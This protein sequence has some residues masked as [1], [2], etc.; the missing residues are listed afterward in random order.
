MFDVSDDAKGEFRRVEVLTGP[1]RR[2]RWSV[3]EKAQ[4]VAETL[5]PGARVSEVARRF[6]HTPGF[7]GDNDQVQCGVCCSISKRGGSRTRVGEIG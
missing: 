5:V 3:D 1:S 6:A 7:S 2:R 4:I